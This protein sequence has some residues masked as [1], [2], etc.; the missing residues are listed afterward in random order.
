LRLLNLTAES[1]SMNASAI[2]KKAEFFAL[3]AAAITSYIVPAFAEPAPMN[4]VTA[5]PVKGPA[6]KNQVDGWKILQKSKFFGDEE[7]LISPLG[8]KV[9]NIRSFRTLVMTPPFQTVTV[10]NLQNKFVCKIPWKA[11]RCPVAKTFALFNQFELSNIP[12]V[13]TGKPVLTNGYTVTTYQTT[14]SYDAQQQILRNTDHVPSSNPGH[15]EVKVSTDFGE[16]PEV[17]S[18][19]CRHFGSP[20]VKGVP[21]EVIISDLNN[22]PTAYVHT[23]KST[24]LKVSTKDFI[25]PGGLKTVASPQQVEAGNMSPEAMQLF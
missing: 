7:I 17:S 12:V 6:P 9:Y 13:K 3:A 15:F 1:K 14:R 22:T 21:M 25:V 4:K 19:L 20:I 11:Y 10:Y 2:Q 5:P 24:K 18:T 16:R 8:L 23:V